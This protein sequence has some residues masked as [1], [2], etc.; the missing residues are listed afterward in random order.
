MMFKRFAYALPNFMS[1]IGVKNF[2]SI[3][4][5]PKYTFFTTIYFGLWHGFGMSTIMY[6]NAMNSISDEIVESA[7][8]DGINHVQELWSIT[9]P[10][11]MPTIST[12]MITSVSSPL[13][14]EGTLFLFWE[15]KAPRETVRLGYLMFQTTMKAGKATYPEV[16]ALGMICTAITFPLTML[17]RWLFDKFDPMNEGVN[18]EKKQNKR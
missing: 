8:L 16:A 11:I 3:I 15:Y 9:L 12:F 18:Y 7:V 6:G 13:I 5:D 1:G 17:V 14:S 4:T 2:P 10:L